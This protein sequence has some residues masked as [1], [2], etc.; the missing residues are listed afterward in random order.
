MPNWLY[1][2]FGE[3]IK[4]LITVKDINDG[5]HLARPLSFTEDKP[6]APATM[7]IHPP[8]AVFHLSRGTQLDPTILYR[9]RVFLWLPHFLISNPTQIQPSRGVIELQEGTLVPASLS[10][11]LSLPRA[12]IIG[13]PEGQQLETLY[14]GMHLLGNPVVRNVGPGCPAFAVDDTLTSVEQ[15]GAKR[16][17]IIPE[18]ERKRQAI[19]TCRRCGKATCPGDSDI[20]NCP[21]PCEVPCKKCGRTEGCR[22]VDG[23]RTCTYNS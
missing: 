11:A 16:R 12:P 8:D 14:T 23:S 2:Y 10:T 6:H 20:F 1:H 15:A 19:R 9:P 17:C 21:L 18:G 22:G 13:F 7:W 5:R 4:T 3:R